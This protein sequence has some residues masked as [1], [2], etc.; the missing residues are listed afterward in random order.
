MATPVD[1]P[2]YLQSLVESYKKQ[3]HLYT[4]T[5][6]Q[7][8][9]RVE[10]PPEDRSQPPSPENKPETKIER[11]EVLAGIRKYVQQGK[12]LLV[13]KPGSGK[14][15]VL[16]RFRW[17][18]ALEALKEGDRP[19]PVLVQLRSDRSIPEAICA[20][21][22]Q[23]K[24]RV[25][26]E[27]VD[28]L[29]FDSRLLLLLDGVN[30]MP[31]QQRRQDLQ[32][33]HDENPDT[34][35]IFTTR[36]LALGGSLGI[37]KQLEMCA[38]TEAQM[39][40][41]VHKHLP[42]HGDLL[43]QQLRD[44]LRE[45]AET[46]LLLEMMCKVF[47]NSGKIPQSK[48]ELFQEFD[49]QYEEFKGGA[50][51]SEDFRRFKSEVLQQLAFV[52]LQG[53][54]QRP[55]DGWVAISRDR[56][57]GI[58]ECWLRDRGVVDAPTKAKEWLED[59]LEH[60]LLQVAAK[61]EEIEFHHQLFQ[62][63][64]AGRALLKLLVERHIDAI[65][66][67]RLQHFYLN[68]FKWTEPLAF[69]LSLL[70]DEQ[71]AVRVV[72]LAL[73]VDLMLG[74]RLAGEVQREFQ[75]RT[76]GLVDELDVPGWLKLELLGEVR[77]DEVIPRLL[78]LVEHSDSNVR[79]SVADALG[80]IGEDQAIS[81]LLKLVEDS[82][83]HV[84]WRAAG[85]L[86]NIGDDQAIPGLLKLVEDSA[87]DVRRRAADALGKIG[88]ERAIPALL[89]LVEDSNFFMR[90]S[91]ADAL[92]KIGSEQ[93]IPGLL[94]LVEHS[95][96]DVRSSTAD[97]LGKIGDERAIPGL[98]KLVEHSDSDV[99]SSAADAL[100]K[101]G[102]E[103]AIPELLK[104][105]EDSDSGV[106]SS[107]ADALGNIG[108]ERAIPGLLKLV[109]DSQP[110][111]RS[112]AAFALGKIGDERAIPGL[113]KLVKYSSSY[114][115]SCA[116]FALGKIGD[117]RAISGL[118]KLVEDSVSYVRSCAAEALGKIGDDR[119]I[120]GLLKLVEDSDFYARKMVAFALGQ[121][122]DHKAIPALLKLVKDSDSEVRRGAAGALGKIG[123]QK[124]IPGLLK[125]VEDSHSYV[126]RSA[127]NVLGQIGDDQAIPGLLKLIED[128]DS[129]VRWMAADALG[130]IG[131]DQ[132]IP[133]LLKLVEDSDYDVRWRAADALG[134]IAK[135]HTEKVAPHLPH[136]FTLI[137]SESGKE[138]HRAI[139]A[140]QAACKYY[141]YPIRHLSLTPH[142]AKPS[143]PTELL[144]KIDQ[145]TQ[146][147]D[148]RTKQ[149]ADQPTQDFSRA[150]FEGP[151]NFGTNHGYQAQNLT[152]AP[153]QSSPEPELNA[154]VQIIQA[155]EKKYSYV[156]DE[157][158]ARKIIHAEFKEIKQQKRIEWQNLISLK[159]LYNGAK[160]AA[161]KVGEH[162]AESSVWG[163]AGVGFIEGISE[164]VN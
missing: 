163:K 96:S 110:Y 143:Q 98:L 79:S 125:L 50:S 77:S 62:E 60:H 41:F 134:N 93:A 26:P 141:N 145:T 29:L 104:L 1:F 88:D 142:P 92:G 122:G 102:D 117:D 2:K 155:L 137:P 53:D 150:T 109:E 111:V 71:Q 56:A 59:L 115:R 107:A 37:E 101:I 15:T 27:E 6:L 70:R 114:V 46:P 119:A 78:K 100:G 106:R 32:L 40:E 68:Y 42:Q 65:D 162:F 38:L 94:K 13:G 39:R 14:S 61:R 35:M 89:K 4:L 55:T 45:I 84:R 75:K 97:A 85:A 57:E 90:C 33:F 138:F 69:M 157:Q 74:A 152:I 12:V 82:N 30:E 103:R 130:K 158:Q 23:A 67:R 118:L 28:D 20:E 153:Q 140:I 132:A 160:N 47:K 66:D 154:V 16:Q 131:D 95:D 149:M 128:S 3:Q 105:V 49:R 44:R 43:L 10:K 146:Q 108:D 135:Q 51:V 76:V 86:G 151:V 9:V 54:S 136:L 124:A 159:R 112:S 80:N 99:R 161:L 52:M 156:Q 5:D 126:R 116:A 31:S 139:L 129:D 72:R 147:I 87:F 25:C 19:I 81:G 11:L 148:Q 123:D 113:L 91:A 144:V 24:L 17:E 120:A 36:D 121:I 63:Y 164:D 64:Y 48:G 18:L 127:A 34:P 133:G 73:K 58:L 8:E 22:R 7:V 21:F 83:S